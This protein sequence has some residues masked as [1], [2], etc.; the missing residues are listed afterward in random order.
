[1]TGLRLDVHRG[2][3]SDAV[4]GAG[5]TN[6]GG[7][8]FIQDATLQRYLGAARRVADHAVIGSGP[9]AFHRDPGNTGFEL[10]AITRIQSI[11]RNHGFRT[12]AGEGGEPFGLERYPKAFYA[13]WLFSHR[14]ALGPG[15]LTMPNWL[16]QKAWTPRFSATF[17]SFFNGE[18]LASPPPKLPVRGSNFPSHPLPL[19]PRH[20]RRSSR[21][22]RKAANSW[23]GAFVTGKIGLEPMLTP[24]KK[25]RFCGPI[26]FGLPVH[27]ASK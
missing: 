6:S 27:N 10:S 23:L 21:R 3:V 5:F 7:V 15:R 8:Q 4:G 20:G 2:F 14:K 16:R 22:S 26:C 17:T 19:V 12:A 13:A 18:I 25:P 11:Y 24:R 1:M 9:L